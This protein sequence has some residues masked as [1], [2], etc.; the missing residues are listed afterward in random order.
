MV[1]WTPPGSADVVM[2]EGGKVGVEVGVGVALLP[3]DGGATVERSAPGVAGRNGSAVPGGAPVASGV[4][5]EGLDWEPP[6]GTGLGVDAPIGAPLVSSGKV[7]VFC[8]YGCVAP[9][10]KLALNVT[11]SARQYRKFTATS[12]HQPLVSPRVSSPNIRI[13]T[14]GRAGR[15]DAHRHR[16]LV[17][18]SLPRAPTPGYCRKSPAARR[19]HDTSAGRSA[20]SARRVA[21]SQLITTIANFVLEP[22]GWLKGS[23]A[24]LLT[25]G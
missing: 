5:V 16:T 3:A 2:C 17:L 8:R 24:A 21:K 13:I 9:L 1:G 6:G 10:A 12:S 20:S 4:A 11:V 18:S 19:C 15:Q 22:A 25:E 14:G 7:A 23:R